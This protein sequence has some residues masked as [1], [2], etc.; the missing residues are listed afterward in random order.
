ME[1]KIGEQFKYKGTTLE[2]VDRANH[3]CEECFFFRESRK[4]CDNIKCSMFERLDYT[5]VY[6]KEV[7]K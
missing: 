1:R 7:K 2:V 3:N 5:F 6:F 4:F